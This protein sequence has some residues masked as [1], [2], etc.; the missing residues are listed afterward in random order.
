M[1]ANKRENTDRRSE[2]DRRSGGRSNYN[3]PERRSQ[4]FRRNDV[5]RRKKSK[6]QFSSV[7]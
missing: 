6:K 2:K 1:M 4:R 7:D 5:N 3:G